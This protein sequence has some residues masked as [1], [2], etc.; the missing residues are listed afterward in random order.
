MQQFRLA[1]ARSIARRWRQRSTGMLL[2]IGAFGLG[3]CG[4]D[5]LSVKTPDIVT[6]EN[7]EG[8]AGL[9]VLRAGAVGDLALAVGGAAAG[10]GS[11]PGLVH[12]T[13]A[14]TDEV[15]Y[16]GTFPTRR[17]F[18]ERRLRDDVGDINV[19]YRNVH[20]ARAAAETAAEAY[21]RLA[22]TDPARAEM[23]ALAGFTQVFLGENFCAGVSISNALP[24]GDLEFGDPL[25]TQALFEL[26]LT[27]FNS[28]ITAA[29]ASSAQNY[30]AS[31][32]KGR[33]LVNLARFTEAAQAVAAVPTS[34][35]MDVEYST[36]SARQQNGVYA[37]SGV[38]RQYSVPDGESAN[39][40][41]FRSLADPRVTWSR[42]AGEVG[43]DGTTPFF[44]QLKYGTAAAPVALATGIEARLIEAEAALQ[45]P[46]N[47]SG[48]SSIHTALRATVGLPAV[49]ASTMSQA[50]RVDFHFRE[51]ALWLYLT[52]HRLGDM[53][54]LVRQ[55]GRNAESVFPTGAYFKGGTY[56]TD[57]NF[58]LPISELNNPKSTGCT[59][60]N[61]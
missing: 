41:P 59:N 44:L 20:R 40:I 13:S 1:L 30:L 46:T 8:A 47:V 28:A 32:G 21:Q 51:R 37:L 2:V 16:S 57:V 56:G 24:S 38:D 19:L 39:G 54:R 61:P 22:A 18:D 48:F 31:V 26:A 4:T 6:P 23:L 52:A 5:L 58:P 3:A 42:T 29:P 43:Q 15:T 12:H 60:R 10:H 27:R 9:G 55:Y 34:F 17:L 25:T 35:R 11:T 45:P 53:R 36:G 49:D 7:L 50:Q 14:F 33:T